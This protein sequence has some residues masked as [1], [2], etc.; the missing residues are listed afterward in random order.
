MAD[1][2]YA[3]VARFDGTRFHA[4]TIFADSAERARELFKQPDYGCGVLMVRT[5]PAPNPNVPHIYD[6]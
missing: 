2:F 5:I 6:L 1:K 4:A 3:L